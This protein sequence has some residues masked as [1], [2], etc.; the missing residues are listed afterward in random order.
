MAHTDI[1]TLQIEKLPPEGVDFQ[2]EVS[3]EELEIAPDDMTQFPQPVHFQLHVAP[4]REGILAQGRLEAVLR[5]RCDKCL[6]YYSHPIATTDV[7]HFFETPDALEIDLTEGIREDILMA[8]PQKRRCH[9]DC[10]GLCPSCGQNL[11]VRDCGCP[12]SKPTGAVW[13]ALDT[14]QLSID[15]EGSEA[16][17]DKQEKREDENPT[18]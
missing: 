4:T 5:C 14:L 17:T 15:D 7:C 16:A 12:P 3:F 18:G 13:T 11:N 1:L 6:T 10:R 2:G 9:P 8:L